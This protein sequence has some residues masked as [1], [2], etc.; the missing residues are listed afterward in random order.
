MG[1]P[2]DTYSIEEGSD[3]ILDTGKLQIV[4]P[5]LTPSAN[6]R[7]NEIEVFWHINFGGKSWRTPLDY[8]YVGDHW[9]DQISSII[10]YGG[11][12]VFY[13]HIN[14]GGATLTLSQGFYPD[15]RKFQ[16]WNDVISSWKEDPQV[17]I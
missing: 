13:E 9:N 17:G 7:L 16:G 6:L 8:S 2:G 10:V 5:K 11:T 4:E 15:I 12:W 14:F 1:K 3:R